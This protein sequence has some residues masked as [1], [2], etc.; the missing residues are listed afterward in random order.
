[1]EGFLCW[2][3]RNY[4]K[5]SLI[6]VAL[7]VLVLG[8]AIWQ[9]ANAGD[10]NGTIAVPVKNTDGSDIPASGAG[11]ITGLIVEYGTCN[12]ASAPYTFGAKLGQLTISPPATSYKIT[13]LAP[14]LYCV[15]G[16]AVNT[17]ATA[18]AAS[19]VVW[20]NVA[21]PVPLPPVL[22]IATIAYELREYSGGTLR[23]V[24]VGTVP[25]GVAC[26]GKLVGQYHG[27]TGAKITKPTTG[28]IIAAK[29]A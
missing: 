8:S 10:L 19:G 21:S 7:L 28:G 18:S 20:G 6:V 12:G 14:G 13:G 5:A 4:L 1:M 22:T 24:Q 25:K 16:Y 11:S 2:L 3:E 29:C 27:F 9:A 26:E 23:F 17:F 15:R